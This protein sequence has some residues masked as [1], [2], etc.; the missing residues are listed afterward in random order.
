MLTPIKALPWTKPRRLSH[1]AL[2]S[3]AWNYMYVQFCI[4]SIEHNN[5][6]SSSEHVP[7]SQHNNFYICNFLCVIDL[8]T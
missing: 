3:D 5:I 4:L 6:A 8:N 1:R 2:K 7:D